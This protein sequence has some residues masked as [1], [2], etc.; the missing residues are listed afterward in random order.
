MHVDFTPCTKNQF[1]DLLNLNLVI[2]SCSQFYFVKK[3]TRNN[4]TKKGKPLLS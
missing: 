3:I 4:E 1:Q 2:F